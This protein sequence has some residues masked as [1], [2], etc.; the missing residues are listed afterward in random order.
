M[1][2][3]DPAAVWRALPKTLQAELR[4]DPK[5]PLNDD[6]LRKCGQ[7][8]DD[9]DLPVFWRPDPDSAYAQH[10]LHPALAAY[11]STH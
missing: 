10:C 4:S 11:I 9:R 5:R 1:T 2:E 3:L 6:L 8:I 7:I